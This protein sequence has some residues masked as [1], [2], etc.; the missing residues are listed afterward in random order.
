MKI[1]RKKKLKALKPDITPLIDVVFLLLLFFLLNSN[2]IK[3]G[4]K[5]E[6]PAVENSEILPPS[7]VEIAVNKDF[8]VFVNQKKVKIENLKTHLK[9]YAPK[10][11]TVIIKGDKNC[12]YGAIIN[13][14]D[15]CKT[16]GFSVINMATES[17]AKPSRAITKEV[18][19]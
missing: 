3:S 13:V 7:R 8:E 4:V 15:Q 11:G 14:A 1:P 17:I 12:V 16:V 5:F 6:I 2:Y 10:G 9:Q 19:R 18:G